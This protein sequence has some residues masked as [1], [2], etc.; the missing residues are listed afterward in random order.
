ML[1]SLQHEFGGA[2][3][4]V[5]CLAIQFAS[6]AA[7]CFFSTAAVYLSMH[8]LT[9]SL[10]VHSYIHYHV[11][12]FIY[13]S[14]A[15]QGAEKD[16]S[17]STLHLS[18]Q[19]ITSQALSTQVSKTLAKPGACQSTNTVGKLVWRRSINAGRAWRRFTN[20]IDRSRY[21]ASRWAQHESICF[22]I[23]GRIHIASTDTDALLLL[24]TYS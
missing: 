11:Y 3:N 1:G 2:T 24:P 17:C 7:A 8:F 19:H 12:I 13:N 15:I 21:R 10:C 20:S 14:A 5:A 9:K 18:E 23:L 22:C 16:P 6:I 4:S